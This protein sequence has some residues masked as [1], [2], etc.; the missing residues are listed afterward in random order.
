MLNV[1]VYCLG[2]AIVIPMLG[3]LAYSY[4]MRWAVHLIES[5]PI[6]SISHHSRFSFSP[7]VYEIVVEYALNLYPF[8]GLILAVINIGAVYVITPAVG[9]TVIIL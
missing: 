5:L 9:L 8:S 2:I 7:T 6:V 4:S 1:A 3:P